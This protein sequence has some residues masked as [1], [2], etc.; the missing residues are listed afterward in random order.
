M[1]RE[2]IEAPWR[3][4]LEG[5][6][7]AHLGPARAQVDQEQPQPPVASFKDYRRRA[8]LARI[9]PEIRGWATGL[10]RTHGG[11]AYRRHRATAKSVRRMAL[12]RHANFALSTS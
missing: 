11:R 12:S 1:R 3:A 6:Y 8:R 5:L 10:W 4:L 9:A 2:E 7:E